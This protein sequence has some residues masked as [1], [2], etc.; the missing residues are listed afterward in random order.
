MVCWIDSD[1]SGGSKH[2]KLIFSPAMDIPLKNLWYEFGDGDINYRIF[3]IFSSHIGN[4]YCQMAKNVD[5]CCAGLKLL[6]VMKFLIKKLYLKFNDDMMCMQFQGP[7][8]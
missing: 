4:A 8:V 1:F 5:K 2:I 7:L 3:V 6:P